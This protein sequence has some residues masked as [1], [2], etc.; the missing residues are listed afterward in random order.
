MGFSTCMISWHFMVK[1][2]VSSKAQEAARSCFSKGQSLPAADDRASLPNPGYLCGL[3][4]QSPGGTTASQPSLPGSRHRNTVRHL[5]S[6]S[7]LLRSILVPKSSALPEVSVQLACSCAPYHA[8]S[9]PSPP[10]WVE[11]PSPFLSV[12]P[13]QLPSEAWLPCSA[14]HNFSWSPAAGGPFDPGTWRTVLFP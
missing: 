10:S 8:G 7:A 12:P 3:G 5:A 14:P 4:L 13:D 11:L 6:F 2:S 1:C 9:G